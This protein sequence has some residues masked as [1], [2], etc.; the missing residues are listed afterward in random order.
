M[1]TVVSVVSVEDTEDTED[2]ADSADGSDE[3][4]GVSELHAP[5]SSIRAPATAPDRAIPD[6]VDRLVMTERYC[7]TVSLAQGTESGRLRTKP[8]KLPG[9]TSNI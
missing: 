1:A 5:S 2:V 6:T 7:F 9:L 3:P 8:R 4:V